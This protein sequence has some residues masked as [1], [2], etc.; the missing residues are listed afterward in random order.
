MTVQNSYSLFE[1]NQHVRRVLALNFGEALWIR[2]EIA[3]VS[4]SQGHVYLSLLEKE[5]DQIRAQADG[6]IWNSVGRKLRMELG[7]VLTQL[8]RTGIHVLIKAR[9]DFNERY[10][11]KLVVE[12]ID[13]SYTM[14]QL[15]LQRQAV[16]GR[17]VAEGLVERNRALSIPMVPQRLAI[18]SSEKAA[19]LADFVHHLEQNSGGYRFAC[20]LFP[21]LMQGDKLKESFVHSMAQINQ[22]AALFD[23]I[24]VIRGGGAKLDLVAFDDYMVCAEVAGAK[25]PVLTGIGHETDETLLDKVAFRSFKTPTAVADWLLERAMYVEHMLN[26][27][28]MRLSVKC[29]YLLHEQQSALRQYTLRVQYHAST[30]IQQQ[31]RQLEHLQTQVGMFVRFHLVRQ[32][33]LLEQ[34]QQLFQ[35]LLPDTQFKRG[36]SIAHQQGRIIRDAKSLQVGD[37]ITTQLANYTLQSTITD[38][39]TDGKEDSKTIG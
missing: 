23:A 28:Q 9:P 25:L 32:R 27:L 11:L 14:G 7:A 2:C 21:T 10:G 1:I 30:S 38:I 16:W 19:G 5:N 31:V 13:P 4:M 3:Q 24:V 18:V 22:Q 36:F 8:L 37:V 29:R 34:Q 26:D 12:D 35:L 17:L 39:K 33:R 15:E 6:V 20:R